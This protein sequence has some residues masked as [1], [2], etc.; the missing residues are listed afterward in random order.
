MEFLF[1]R[2]DCSIRKL[3][4]DYCIQQQPYDDNNEW[5]TPYEDAAFLL[6]QLITLC[7]LSVTLLINI[8]KRVRELKDARKIILLIDYDNKVNGVNG[9]NLDHKWVE[10][11]R[12][13]YPVASYRKETAL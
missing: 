9:F 7:F 1:D 2:S 12:W 5:F 11:Y 10:K 13:V 4:E 6:V 3:T 8:I